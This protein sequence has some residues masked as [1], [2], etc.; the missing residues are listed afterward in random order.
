[1]TVTTST[2]R[3]IHLHFIH[4]SHDFKTRDG[5][6]EQRRALDDDAI[7]YGLLNGHRDIRPRRLTLCTLSEVGGTLDAHGK[8]ENYMVL[9]QGIG[10]CHPKD[11]FLKPV[12][13]KAALTAAMQASGMD[14][15]ERKSIWDAYLT[16]FGK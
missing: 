16:Q 9:G 2:G 3:T 14:R 1:M 6:S 12:G 10:V 13:R 4:S 15:D 5:A 11:A 8:P 7:A